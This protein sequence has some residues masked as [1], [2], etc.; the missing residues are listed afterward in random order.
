MPSAKM[1]LNKTPLF[2]LEPMTT[3]GKNIPD[4]GCMAGDFSVE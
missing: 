2:P 4:P 1:R 3:L